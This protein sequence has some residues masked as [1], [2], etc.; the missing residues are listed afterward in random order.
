[1]FFDSTATNFAGDYNGSSQV[2]RHGQT[3]GSTV[4]LSNDYESGQAGNGPSS[5]PTAASASAPY[6]YQS[7]AS[8]LNSRDTNGVTDVFDNYTRMSYDDALGQS[9]S[10]SYSPSISADGTIT[11]FASASTAWGGTLPAI[12]RIFFHR[13]LRPTVCAIAIVT[14]GILAIPRAKQNNARE[15]Y[16][17]RVQLQYGS[18][19][20][21]TPIGVPISQK[22]PITQAQVGAALDEIYAK[23][24]GSIYP[25]NSGEAG[26]NNA[27]AKLKAKIISYTGHGVCDNQPTFLQETWTVGRVEWR[28]DMDNFS[29]C[30]LQY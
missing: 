17:L 26:L 22:D 11:A 3:T 7:D 25:F 23:A 9:S 8:N 20:D 12:P 30:N 28:I 6:A 10:P 29:G 24:P 15:P 1:M 2:F 16:R 18:G 19:L 5:Y 4:R 13:Y 14:A 27:I 21:N